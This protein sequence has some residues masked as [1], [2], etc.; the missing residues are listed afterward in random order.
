M[1]H[2]SL[3]RPT[4][5]VLRSCG[6]TLARERQ[7]NSRYRSLR[8]SPPADLSS[9]DARRTATIACYLCWSAGMPPSAGTEDRVLCSWMVEKRTLN[10]LRRADAVGLVRSE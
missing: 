5:L 6:P 3:Q 7:A 8:M 4:P 2:S 9:N 10:G 1:Y